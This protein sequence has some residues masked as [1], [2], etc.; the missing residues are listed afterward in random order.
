LRT[1][2][3]IVD[4]QAVGAYLEYLTEAFLFYRV[5]RYDV[6]GK[7]LLQTLDKYYVADLGLRRFRLGGKAGDDRGHLLENVVYLELRRRNREVYVGKLRNKEVDFVAV[8]HK[9]YVSYYQVA[10]SVTD[11]ATLERELA[12]LRAI[13]DSNPKYLLSADWDTNP[14]YDGIRKLNVTG[15]LLEDAHNNQYK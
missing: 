4:K 8:D 6:K 15:W 9:G 2:G 3:I 11:T 10:Y 5:P 14:V 12:P 1:N 7:Q 13:R